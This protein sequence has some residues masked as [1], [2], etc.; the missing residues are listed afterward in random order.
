MYQQS[1]SSTS[2]A[3]TPAQL[4]RSGRGSFFIRWMHRAQPGYFCSAFMTYCLMMW[5]VQEC[6]SFWI[7]QHILCT[8]RTFH[9]QCDISNPFRMNYKYQTCREHSLTLR[10]D[11][12]HQQY[13][14]QLIGWL[15]HEYFV[16]LSYH[17]FCLWRTFVHRVYNLS[18]RGEISLCRQ[19]GKAWRTLA[20]ACTPA[21]ARLH[22][23][24]CTRPHTL[25]RLTDWFSPI[26]HTPPT[27][28]AV[29]YYWTAPFRLQIPIKKGGFRGH[30]V[31]TGRMVGYLRTRHIVGI[32][33]K[34]FHSHSPG[35]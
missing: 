12:Q 17:S 23:C 25:K 29:R 16:Y 22:G 21:W 10:N 18:D 24:V 30:I 34:A 9:S 19:R 1:S 2:F 28:I 26:L 15:F 31:R 20:H 3:H 8:H 11:H 14:P 35:N 27:E 6:N 7:S 13:H 32:Y 5:R 4:H 33:N